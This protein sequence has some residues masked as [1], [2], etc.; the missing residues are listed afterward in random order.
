V[1]ESSEGSTKLFAEP[2]RVTNLDECFFYHAMDLPVHGSVDGYWD[3]RGN[4]S[5]YLGEVPFAGKRVLEIGPASGHISFFMERAGAEVISVEAA[6]NYPWEFFWNIPDRAPAELADKLASHR[7][8]M[9]RLRSSYWLAHGEFLSKARVHYGSAYFIPEALGLF[10][11]SVVGC[12]LLHNKHPLQILEN[13]ARLT[14][15]TIVV[16]EVFRETQL[17]ESPA[18]F[19][20]TASERVWHT[21]WSFS[22]VY[23]IDILRSMGFTEHRV[24]FHRQ[25]CQGVPTA[26]FTVV[27]SRKPLDTAPRNESEIDVTISSIVEILKI[28]AGKQVKIPVTIRNRGKVPLSSSTGQP[29]LLSYHWQNESEETIVWDGLRTPLLRTLYP[30]DEEDILLSVLAPSE[31]G[32]YVLNITLLKEHVTWYDA[33]IPGLPLRVRTT[34]MERQN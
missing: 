4:E 6:E 28:E 2:R 33:M 11:V 20:P 14:K 16:V 15:E 18:L 30:D 8:M 22:P 1:S 12:V 25:I 34:V 17:P 29:V 3:L 26:L 21:W 32:Q 24:T 19:K 31:A 23:F 13:C 10:D 27:A 7:E 9:N 5:Q